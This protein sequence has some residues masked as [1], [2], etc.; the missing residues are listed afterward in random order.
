MFCPRCGNQ[1]EGNPRVCENCGSTLVIET[2]RRV[3][4]KASGPAKKPSTAAIVTVAVMGIVVAFHTL[5]CLGANISSEGFNVL[6]FII[7]CTAAVPLVL[8]VYGIAQ[9][10]HRIV[11]HTWIDFRGSWRALLS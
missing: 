9:I 2:P 4:H 8:V 6:F 1:Y 5:A 10:T 3:A 7:E 11:K